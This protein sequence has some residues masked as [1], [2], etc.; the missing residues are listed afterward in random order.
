MTLAN[1]T[2]RRNTREFKDE[3]KR[4]KEAME[5][6][7]D[8]A[9][10]TEIESYNGVLTVIKLL[11]KKLKEKLKEDEAITSLKTIDG[12]FDELLKTVDK[13][14]VLEEL[15]QGEGARKRV[16]VRQFFATIKRFLP[17]I[18]EQRKTREI[19]LS[20]RIYQKQKEA[21][22]ELRGDNHLLQQALEVQRETYKRDK[23]TSRADEHRI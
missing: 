6:G 20:I 11:E 4:Y 1:L 2:K 5:L 17:E 15:C 3:L 14:I 8:K 10:I 9:G 16:D 19:I 13:S 12:W 22:A 7:R 18:D 23:E 21:Q